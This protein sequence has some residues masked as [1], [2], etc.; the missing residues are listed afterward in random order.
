MQTVGEI[1]RSEREKKGLTV[2]DIEAATSIRALYIQ[3]IE[4]G[5]YGIAPGEVYLKGF[6]RNYATYLGLDSQQMLETYKQSKNPPP[7]EPEPEQ[8]GTADPIKPSD[9]RRE[10]RAN[11]TVQTEKSGQSTSTVKWLGIALGVA[12]IAGAGWWYASATQK[13]SI[14]PSQQAP[15]PVPAP[16]QPSASPNAPATPPVKTK[17]VVITVKITDDC[18]AQVFADGKEV[19]AGL[20]KSGESRTWEADSAIAVKF[21]NAG[22]AEFTHNGRN[23]GKLGAPGEVVTRTFTK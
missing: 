17:P 19:Y 10:N 22:A 16:V 23:V 14:P 18:W 1:L 21:G 2:K 3:A 13:P 9:R 20:L 4:E 5:N 11:R 6:I 8:S 12:I 7:P 15:I